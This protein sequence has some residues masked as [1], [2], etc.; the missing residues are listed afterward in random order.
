[1]KQCFDMRGGDTLSGCKSEKEKHLRHLEK[2]QNDPPGHKYNAA[3]E[4]GRKTQ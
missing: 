1:M 3:G 4:W 2:S